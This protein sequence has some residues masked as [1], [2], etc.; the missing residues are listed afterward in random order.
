[1]SVAFRIRTSAGQEL[2]FASHEMFE[3]FVRSGDLS[4]DDLVYDGESGSWA[5]ARTHPI[6]LDIEY[7]KEARAESA[8]SDAEGDSDVNAD[9]GSTPAASEK[10]ADDEADD[11]RFGLSLAPATEV[12]EDDADGPSEARPPSDGSTA[13]GAAES[14]EAGGGEADEPFGFG[15]E[16]APAE[17]V[18]QEEA[19]QA[20]VDK[21]DAA[22]A[23]EID[24]GA[25][26]DGGGLS[27]TM[28]GSSSLADM[29]S[30]PVT[31]DPTPEPPPRT[32]PPPTRRREPAKRE[33]SRS[34]P[35]PP[36]RESTG[37][38]LKKALVGVVVLA[39]IGAAGYFGLQFTADAP[40]VVEADPA[41]PVIPIEV[42]PVAPE[43]PAPEPVIADTEPAVRERAQERFLT[44]TQDALRDLQPIP[45]EWGTGGYLSL[46]S[47][48]ADIATTWQTY[49]TTI[50][51]VR[52]E[53][54]GR[55]RDAYEEALD[56]AAIVGEAARLASRD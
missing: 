9:D 27:F 33:S 41:V 44:A 12:E 46:P 56:D 14:A 11:G 55:Y 47:S 40:P 31:P 51:Q 7:E 53:D 45:E 36:P 1:M 25:G 17:V 23:A 8:T 13:S 3:D 34:E 48:H 38:G 20:F 22:R 15:L 18:S 42:E 10:L 35:A 26:D 43:P 28:E 29:I 52:N 6:V 49:L 2:S 5:P 16:L 4:P 50:R 37:G 19:A 54:A 32:P 39:A 30:E 24:V 21:M